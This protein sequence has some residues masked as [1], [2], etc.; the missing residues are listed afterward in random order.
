MVIHDTYTKGKPLPTS[1]IQSAPSSQPS[2][3][4]R[5]GDLSQIWFSSD[6]VLTFVP[7]VPTEQCRVEVSARCHSSLTLPRHTTVHSTSPRKDQRQAS[8][9]SAQNTVPSLSISIGGPPVSGRF[10]LAISRPPF[11]VALSKIWA[12]VSE[13]SEAPPIFCR[14]RAAIRSLSIHQISDFFPN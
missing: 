14:I 9:A 5:P 3:V 8:A 10:C 4:T 12:R 13:T 7:R 11:H 6:P 2:H 1:A